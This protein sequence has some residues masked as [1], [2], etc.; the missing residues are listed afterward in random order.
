MFD[1]LRSKGG[2]LGWRPLHLAV[3]TA[4]YF[5]PSNKNNDVKYIE[6]MAM[7]HYLLDLNAPDLPVGSKTLPMHS[8]TPNC[9]I[10]NENQGRDNRELTW[11]L[12]DRGADPTDALRFIK[13]DSNS[14]EDV[15]A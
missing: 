10:Y 1:L 14:A 6:R 8:G 3:E 9:Y 4:T 15:K 11:L 5:I 13:P 7:V 12:L 2:P